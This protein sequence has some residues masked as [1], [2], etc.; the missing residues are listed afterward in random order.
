MRRLVVLLALLPLAAS[1]NPKETIDLL[2]A[3]KSLDEAALAPDGHR[4]AYVEKQHNADRT[5]SRNSFIYVIDGDDAKPRRVT[6]GNG[7]A[8]PIMRSYAS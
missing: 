2:F 8:A 6:A 3:V 1:A 4:L 5:E 7:T